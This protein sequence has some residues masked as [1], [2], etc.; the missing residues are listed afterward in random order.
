MDAKLLQFV[1]QVRLDVDGLPDAHLRSVASQ[2]LNLVEEVSH[3]NDRLSAE[4][5][6]L[7]ECL[8]KFQ[9]GSGVPPSVG[10]A[11]LA[12]PPPATPPG[13]HS[14]EKERRAREG[15]KPQRR[16]GTDGRSFR[17]IRVDRDV[18]CPVDQA[19]LPSDA[20][21]VGY[22]D[23][24]VQDLIVTT[25]NVR[26]RCEIWRSPSRGRQRGQLPPEVRGEFGSRLRTLLVSLKYVAGTS[27]PR[28]QE[29]VEHFGIVISPASVVNILHDAA[30]RLAAEREDLFRA[31]LAAT[32]YQHID[33]TSARVGGEFWHTHLIGNS[34]HASYFTRPHKDRLT[35]LDLLRGG[36][37]T[38]RFDALTQRLLREFHV[39]RKWRQRA[40]ELPPDRDFSEQEL[41]AL[42]ATWHPPPPA[43]LETLREAAA[44]ASYWAPPDHVRIL[45]SDDAKQFRHLADQSALCWIHEGR[46]YKRLSPVVP[47]HQRQLDAFLKR[48]WDYYGELRKYQAA[49]SAALAERLRGEFNHLFGTATGYDALDRRIAKTR[50]KKGP[51]LTVLEHPETPLHNNPAELDERVAARR[52]DVSLQVPVHSEELIFPYRRVLVQIMG[53]GRA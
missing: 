7:R 1:R 49:P 15:K 47:C 16:P 22:E 17:P 8:R 25:D 31:G 24:V 4:N 42:L 52:R 38:Y 45:I 46:H 11:P 44:I 2:V 35:V 51:L 36:P 6:R 41:Q 14:S 10:A 30:A 34:L 37:P 48:Y 28:A 26:Y 19:A 9:G 40:E 43:Y 23:V 3:E 27:L 21:F 20:V 32:S 18:L 53:H 50:K 13:N 39:P 33:D 5:A 12:T 29:L